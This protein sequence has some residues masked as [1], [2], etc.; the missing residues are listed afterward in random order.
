MAECLATSP[1]LPKDFHTIF[2][3]DENTKC[4][5]EQLAKKIIGAYTFNVTVNNTI[6]GIDR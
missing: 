6:S 2:V 1:V 5:V 3:P 4:K